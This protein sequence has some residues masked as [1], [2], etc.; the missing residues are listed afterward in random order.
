[1]AVSILI[2]LVVAEVFLGFLWP[3]NEA[4]DLTGMTVKDDELGHRLVPNYS[5]VITGVLSDYRT[6]VETNSHG[7]RSPEYDVEPEPGTVRLALFGDS[8]VFGVGVDEQDMLNRKMEELLNRSGG[9][10]EVLN[11]AIPGTGT[12]VQERLL[13]RA[14]LDWDLDV[15]IFIVTVANDLS[16]N[17]RFTRTEERR[18]A[19]AEPAAP[20]QPRK[21]PNPILTWVKGLNL[22][23]LA[24]F[25]V[26]P[27][28]PGFLTPAARR[29]GTVPHSV[30]T[31]YANDSLEAD[32]ALLTGAL[33]RA[34]DSCAERGVKLYITT[35]PSRSQFVP[36][37]IRLMRNTVDPSVLQKVDADPS[38]PQRMLRAFAEEN[39]IG[40][41]E[42]VDEFRA[43]ADK[44]ARLRHPNDGHLNREGTAELARLLAERILADG[45]AGS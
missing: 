18:K 12:I 41:V 25:K 30:A 38:R 37:T 7:F 45:I 28:L 3:G 20:A 14:A 33:L 5:K 43:L 8:E 34:R 15:A 13:E 1:L 36:A 40:Y 21:R 19:P 26:L 16:D 11:F 23:R 44:G 17:V 22:Y 4:L 35:A 32:F 39:G 31:W 6:T 27:H 2:T 9:R 10:Y 24:V 42:V 29:F